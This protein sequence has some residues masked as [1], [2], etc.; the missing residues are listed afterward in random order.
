MNALP[1]WRNSTHATVKVINVAFD[2]PSPF[3]F[4]VKRV[5]S[6]PVFVLIHLDGFI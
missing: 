6:P 5:A 4:G 1:A 3:N 2:V